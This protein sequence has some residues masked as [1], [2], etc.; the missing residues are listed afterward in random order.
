[1]KKRITT[2][3][4]VIVIVIAA[5]SAAGCGD[6]TNNFYLSPTATPTATAQP[7]THVPP[8]TPPAVPTAPTPP[9]ASADCRDVAPTYTYID[10]QQSATTL[11]LFLTPSWKG[12]GSGSIN[13]GDGGV[14]N[15]TNGVRVSHPYQR[16]GTE[17]RYV[18]TLTVTT[19]STSCQ[20][21]TSEVPIPGTGTSPTPA[22]APAPPTTPPT[23]QPASCSVIN[24]RMTFAGAEKPN[25]FRT[26]TV[27]ATWNGSGTGSV[28]FDSSAGQPTKPV[29]QGGN[30][31]NDYN[32]TPP[33]N[34]TVT[35]T[36]V[37]NGV[38]CSAS[39]SSFTT[40]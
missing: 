4:L 6:E 37:V 22:P 24:P 14:E 39:S 15:V 3:L 13:W 17:R 31:S 16:Q 34:Y 30:V 26:L 8:P 20:W 21:H 5:I 18:A 25:N 10:G 1:M 29:S 36:V 33:R 12:N 9:T 19:D 7:T 32:R 23:Q 28:N 38:T 11:T 27:T 2:S 35:L 40:Q